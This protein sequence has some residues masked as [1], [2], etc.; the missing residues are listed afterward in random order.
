RLAML[1]DNILHRLGLHGFTIIPILLGFGCNVPGIIATRVLES[2]RERFIAA[3]I[4]AIGVPCVPLQAMIFGFLGKSGGLYV[5]GVYLTLLAVIIILGMI[6]NRFLKGYSP[7]LLL[8]IPP[9]RLPPLLLLFKKL[10]FRIKGFLIDAMPV[11]LLGVLVI[12]VLLFFKLFDLFVMAFEP[13]INGLF[14]LPKEA[15]AGLVIGFLRKD[16]A[17]GMLMPLGLSLKQLLVATVLLAMSFPCVATFAVLLK[18]LGFKDFLKSVFVMLSVG[19]VVGT[20]L[21]LL[22]PG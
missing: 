19:I 17:V 7:E 12:N 3:T 8:E 20:L 9:Y 11:V 6:L 4:I 2:R 1:L 14:G 15:V 22:I 21:N 10:Y 16:V 5:A 18:E 13:V